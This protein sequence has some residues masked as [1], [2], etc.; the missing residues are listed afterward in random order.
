MMDY[1]IIGECVP[2]CVGHKFAE[3]LGLFFSRRQDQS[4]T[5][6]GLRPLK[7]IIADILPSR[8]YVRK[9]VGLAPN[10][11]VVSLTAGG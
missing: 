1:L 2:S 8:V 7:L 5:E 6:S 10:G 4:L 9:P 3:S 11:P